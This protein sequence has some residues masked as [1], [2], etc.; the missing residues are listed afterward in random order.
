MNT[1]YSYKAPLLRVIK[2]LTIWVGIN[3]LAGAVTGLISAPFGPYDKWEAQSGFLSVIFIGVGLFYF[4][5]SEYKIYPRTIARMFYIDKWKHFIVAFKYLSLYLGA[6]VTIVAVLVGLSTLFPAFLE[7]HEGNTWI[8]SQAGGSSDFLTFSRIWPSLSGLLF[9][10]MG[11]SCVVPIIEELFYRRVL[12]SELRQWT[13]FF[14]SMLISSF[15]FGLFHSNVVISGI[16][17]VYLAYVYEKEKSL[18][19]N[20]L[21]HSFLNTFAILLMTGLRYLQP[22]MLGNV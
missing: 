11:A 10:F 1:E 14:T 8:L 21:L 15:I 13:G 2:L 17:G 4:T 9:Y 16:T 5:A 7:G 20:I 19:V 6:F 18:S 12:F 3:V 22:Q